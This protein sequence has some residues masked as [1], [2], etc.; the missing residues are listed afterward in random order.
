MVTC[1]WGGVWGRLFGFR[2]GCGGPFLMACGEEIDQRPSSVELRVYGIK[3]P[4]LSKIQPCKYKL[5][6][7]LDMDI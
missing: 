6:V 5:R 7:W 2:V 3:V 4:K 1:S